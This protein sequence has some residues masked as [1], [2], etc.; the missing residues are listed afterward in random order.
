MINILNKT[1]EKI[2]LFYDI[3]NNVINNYNN[4][5]LNYKILYNINNIFNNNIYEDIKNIV[6]EEN[7]N[8]KFYSIIKIN[9]G[10]LNKINKIKLTYEIN[11]EN[12]K[13]KLFDSE[14]V[15]NNI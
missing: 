12:K 2:E 7:I 14:F 1:T 6:E 10:I 5:K 15:K 11:K 8:E 9:I 3:Y 13:V 4:K